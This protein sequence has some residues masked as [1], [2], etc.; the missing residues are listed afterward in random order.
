M[1]FVDGVCHYE[2]LQIKE[3]TS[4]EAL[5]KNCLKFLKIKQNFHISWHPQSGGAVERTNKTIMEVLKKFISGV[6]KDWDLALPLV[7]MALRSTPH[8]STGLSPHEVMTG[9]K[10]VL[11]HHLVFNFPMTGGGYE[12]QFS[13]VSELQENL[14]DIFAFVRENLGQAARINTNLY[15]RKATNKEYE[16]EDK[17][18]YFQFNN[19]SKRKKKF[20]V[21]WSGPF[22][23]V[24]KVS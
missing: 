15:E 17:V 12:T 22:K 1:Y 2:F 16:V 24:G 21:C 19:K 9:R 3:L 10:M 8:T 5:F 20:L 13:Y 4:L 7:M 14:R 11:L 18:Y 23:I 6:G